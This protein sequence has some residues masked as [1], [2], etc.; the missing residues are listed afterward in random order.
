MWVASVAS[1]VCLIRSSL[2][3]PFCSSYCKW[4]VLFPTS[5]IELPGFVLAQRVVKCPAVHEA[6]AVNF[7]IE[8]LTKTIGKARGQW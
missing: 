7:H 5:C 1:V 2:L 4:L 6:T 3:P 8:K